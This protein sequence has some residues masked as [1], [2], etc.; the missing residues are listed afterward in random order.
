M[1]SACSYVYADKF[2]ACVQNVRLPNARMLRVAHATGQWMRRG[3]LSCSMLLQT[4]NRRCRSS[5]TAALY[6]DFVIH[7]VKIWT[8][9]AT[10]PVK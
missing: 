7:R 9:V 4:F 10:V 5:S 3:C 1:L 8:V 2:T 6:P